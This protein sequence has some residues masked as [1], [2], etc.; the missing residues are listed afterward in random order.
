MVLSGITSA[1]TATPASLAGLYVGT[2]GWSYPTWK[3][4][5][6]P[7]DVRPPDFLR[8][9]AERF[10][11]VELNT[12]GYRLPR[13][14]LFERW[15]EQTP[16]GFLFAP[17]LNAHRR[18]D[19]G[20]FAERVRLLGK[21]LGPIRAVVASARDEGLLA[22]LLG[23]F[24][25]SMQLALDLRHD[26]WDGVE[27]TLPPNAVRVNAL[28]GGAPF[29]YLRLREPPYDDAA[30]AGWA[31]RLRPLLDEGLGV[32]CYFKHEDEPTGPAY[33]E[34]LLQLTSSMTS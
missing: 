32:Y 18:S 34:K 15:A 12:T 29:R 27:P 24:D 23:S 4:G 31:E 11:T 30:L 10:A 20:T 2:S 26:S 14:E 8:H 7:A 1:V 33:A 16:D 21:R 28:E 6:Y 5:F 19:F 13:E 22:L 3:P 9:Y 17:K 25:P